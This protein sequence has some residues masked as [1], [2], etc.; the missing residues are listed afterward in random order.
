MYVRTSDVL[1]N[2][3]NQLINGREHYHAEIYKARGEQCTLSL[4]IVKDG[5]GENSTIGVFSWQ[6]AS[7]ALHFATKSN[8]IYL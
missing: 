1:I 5:V 7:M 4:S 2:Y 8:A 6:T 3:W